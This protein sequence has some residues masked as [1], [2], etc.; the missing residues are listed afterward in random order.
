MPSF[1]IEGGHRLKGSI[2][3]QGAKNEALQ[4]LCATLLTA[5]PVRIKNLPN[6]ADVN[7]QIA[8]LQDIGVQVTRHGAGDVELCAAKVNTDFLQS[9]DFLHRCGQLLHAGCRLF[10]RSG[11]LLGA[12]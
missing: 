11:L 8:L 10:Q 5:E 3:P 12:R 1:I 9:A 2:V 6:I 7:N 4:V